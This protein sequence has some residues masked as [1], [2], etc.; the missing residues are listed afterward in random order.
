MGQIRSRFSAD[1]LLLGYLGLCFIDDHRRVIG[2]ASLAML[3]KIY[4]AT[5][6]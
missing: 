2:S 6:V 5:G 4:V 1:S 3:T